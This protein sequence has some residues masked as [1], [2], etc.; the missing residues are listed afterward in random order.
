MDSAPESLR[1]RQLAE[2]SRRLRAEARRLTA[3]RGLGGFTVEE[4]CSE[5]GVS[6]RTF[7]NYFASKENAVLGIAARTDIS[8]LDEAFLASREDVL[9]AV[10]ELHIARWER[11]DMSPAEVPA[12]VA[13][14]TRAPQ[15][16][17]HLL[18][19]AAI[20]ERE[21][22]ALVARR[23]GWAEDD[24]RAA[25]AV[26]LIT[27]LIRPTVSEYFADTGEDF[28]TVMM[29]KLAIARAFFAA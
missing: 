16:V 19:I 3:E 9:D 24:P 11:M 29:R 17:Q 13:A 7:F 20:G 1:S 28:R 22:A 2:T 8:D 12:L 6:R 14:F 23:E 5:V 25:I 21:D 26:Q 4:V 10:A 15:L 27:A 18:D